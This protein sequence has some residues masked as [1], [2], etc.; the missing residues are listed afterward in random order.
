MHRAVQHTK[1]IGGPHDRTNQ[2]TKAQANFD[3]RRK[4]KN[5]LLKA[6]SA[7]EAPSI[8]GEDLHNGDFK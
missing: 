7:T 6:N 2:F 8:V 5:Q 1:F 4:L 3:K